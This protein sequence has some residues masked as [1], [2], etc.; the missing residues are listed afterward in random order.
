MMDISVVLED[1]CIFHTAL[2]PIQEV[3]NSP[4]STPPINGHITSGQ[5]AIVLN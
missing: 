4:L 1:L 2:L 3:F 5:C